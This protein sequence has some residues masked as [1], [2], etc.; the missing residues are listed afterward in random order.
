MNTFNKYLGLLTIYLKQKLNINSVPKL[1][2]RNDTN[3]SKNILGKTGYYSPSEK[4]IVIYINNRHPKDI[5]KT[6][7]HEFI[8]YSQ[9][10]EGRLNNIQGS[11]VNNDE[12]LQK[13]EEETYLKSQ[14]LFRQWEDQL[15]N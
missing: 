6:F 3:N 1:I 4:L 7:S 15:K 14:I 2:L 10:L 12:Y 13:I 11:N 5:L 9:D 8:H